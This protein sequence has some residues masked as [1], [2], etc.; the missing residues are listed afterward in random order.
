MLATGMALSTMNNLKGEGHLSDAERRL[1]TRNREIPRVTEKLSTTAGRPARR[2]LDPF[3]L[4]R[5]SFE[6]GE[7]LNADF[8]STFAG[9]PPISAQCLYELGRLKSASLAA[10]AARKRPA[11]TPK[12]R[13]SRRKRG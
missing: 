2:S 11:S 12:P 7:P 6:R 10:H 13:A 8:G 1:K 3:T 5:R 9:W 4:G